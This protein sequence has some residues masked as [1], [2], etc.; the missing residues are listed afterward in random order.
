ML[1]LVL[2]NLS[3]GLVLMSCKHC[4]LVIDQCANEGNQL[5]DLNQR[6]SQNG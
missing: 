6:V 1:K 5:T 2:F 4:Q 3:L